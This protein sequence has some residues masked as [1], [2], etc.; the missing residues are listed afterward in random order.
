MKKLAETHHL[1]KRGAAWYYRRRVPT[2]LRRAFGVLIQQSLGTTSKKTAIKNREIL[3]V[4][5]SK[6]FDAAEAAQRPSRHAVE[7]SLIQKT[8]LSEAEGVERVRAYVEREDER[9]RKDALTADPMDL[10]ERSEW[11]KELE[12][13]LAIARGRARDY[14][15]EEFISRQWESIFPRAE[16]AV[17]EETNAAVCDMVQR[18]E[19]ELARRRLARE[20]NDHRHSHF[21]RLFD[22]KLPP[23]VTVQE[24]AEQYL[25]LKREEGEA[26]GLA[27]KTLDKQH[28]NLKLVREILGTET[29]VRD[30]NWDACRRFCSVLAQVPPN[31]TKFYPGQPLDEAIAGAKQDGRPGL[32]AVTQQEY[33]STLKELLARAVKKDPDA[34]VLSR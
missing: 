4:E 10:E 2:H 6:K 16:V 29:M 12:I 27:R 32:S 23:A 1:Q 34:Q 33:L 26:H 13:D 14:D 7:T 19:I 20:R 30:L 3:D 28:A 9:H 11:E 18:A 21:D 24:L 31:R 17:D 22:P 8:V 15:L 5:W 25:E